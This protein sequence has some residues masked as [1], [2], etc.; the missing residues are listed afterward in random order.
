MS[1]DKK[2]LLLLFDRPKEPIFAKKGDDSV[3][4]VPPEYLTD[5]YKPIAT[6]LSNRFGE[7][8][9]EKIPVKMISIPPL[10]EILDLSRE[11][12]FSLFIPKHQKLADRLIRI[13]MGVRNTDDLMA[14]A[15]YARDRV[16]PYLFNYAFSVALLHRPDTKDLDVPSIVNFF[17]DKFF[18]SQTFVKAREETNIVSSGSRVPIEIPVDYTASDLEPE[19][20]L[21]YFREDLGVN[22]HHWHW[23]LVYPGRGDR[24]IIDKNRRGELFF[25]MHQQ[26]IARYNME[27][28]CHGFQ[29]VERWIDWKNPIPLAYFPK[30]DSLVAS[31]AYPARVANQTIQDLRIEAEQV[32]LDVDSMYRWRDRIFGAIHQGFV[33]DVS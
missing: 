21:A 30:L 5:R 17:P 26:I 29:R 20:K 13:F 23:H 10:G 15:A 6:T 12:N 2:K 24:T 27:R 4:E 16:N 9:S 11:D 7:Q 8:A 28:L 32:Y 14:V 33:N 22:L 3:F 1:A 31:R 25:Y 18:D 19:H